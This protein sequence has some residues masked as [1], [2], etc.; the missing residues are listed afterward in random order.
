MLVNSQSTQGLNAGDHTE[1]KT[2]ARDFTILVAEDS[3]LDRKLLER[4]LAQL[5]CTAVFAK[6]GREA[7]RLIAQHQPDLIITDWM[8]PD[9]TGVDLCQLIRQNPNRPYTYIIILTGLTERTKLVSG[10][11]AGADDYL[12][13][14]F[15]TSELLA[16]VGVGQRTV[17]LHRQL[18]AKN[19]QLESLARTDALT[20]LPNRRAVEEWAVRELSA[21]VRHDFPF[22]VVMA[23]LDHFKSINDT[24]GHDAGDVVLKKF[25]ATLESSLRTSDF[26]GRVGG[27]EF[28]IVLKHINSEGAR[29]AV[30]RI[31]E[32]FAD[33]RF[34]FGGRELRV[35]A[36]FG[37]AGCSSRH[38]RN[39]R[40]L[41]AKADEALYSAKRLGGNRVELALAE[42]SLIAS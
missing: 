21:A 28:L 9:M 41:I 35:T 37:I 31:R 24:H 23:D 42:L 15:Q 38:S 11:E 13:K 26:C 33:Q 40:Q 7:L 5:R 27:E 30:E 18:E 8:M 6:D 19:R 16:R 32:N 22:W 17:S 25:A 12:T 29:L 34:T 36:S 3:P 20:G 39:F 2:G 4:S 14:P 10:L 1:S